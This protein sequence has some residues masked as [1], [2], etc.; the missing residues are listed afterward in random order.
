[1][2][3]AG[4]GSRWRAPT[5]LTDYHKDQ[6]SYTKV[7]NATGLFVTMSTALVRVRS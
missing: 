2:H 3:R 5:V 6:Q 1:M 4:F 7:F